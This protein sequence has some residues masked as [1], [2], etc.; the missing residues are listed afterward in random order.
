M[1]QDPPILFF[2][3]DTAWESWLADHYDMQTGVWL[4]FAKKSSGIP[5]L[6]YAE[7]L[8]VGLCYG[9]ID[10][11]TR[12]V[13]ETY[14]LQ[15]FT[16]RRPKSTWSKVNVGKVE[17]LIA[18]GK[19]RAPGQAQIDAAK[20]DGRWDNAYESQATATIPDDFAAALAKNEKAQAFYDTLTKANKYSFWFRLKNAKTP[21]KREQLIRKFL[22][23]LESGKAFH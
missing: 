19:M 3:D 13:D 6:N 15:K 21:E 14:Y 16:P 4:K 10:G 23:M 12:S 2:A 8:D 17:A 7:A 5:S 1:K 20:A 18:A 11:Q 9:W 22:T